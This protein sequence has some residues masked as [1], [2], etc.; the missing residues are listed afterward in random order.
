MAQSGVPV[1]AD[2]A[3]MPV[4]DALLADIGDYQSIEQNLSTFSAHVTN[5]DFI[6]RTATAGRS[7]CW[8]NWDRP[9]IP[10]KV[11]LWRSDFRTLWPHRLHDRDFDDHTSLKVYGANTS[12]VINASIGFDET[13][14]QP[15]YELKMACLGHRRESTLRSA[16]G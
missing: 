14:F 11:P 7:S 6:S 2:H 13:T 3:E 10:K 12:G 15:T 1:P 4:F 9:P 8:T 5:I 16:W